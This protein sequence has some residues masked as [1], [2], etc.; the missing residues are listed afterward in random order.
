[1]GQ[2]DV[3]YLKAIVIVHG[4]SEYQICDFIK[5]KLKLNFYI[6]S[7]KKGEKS[8]QIKSVMNILK[9][10][11][12]KNFDAF[13][14]NFSAVELI[15]VEKENEKKKGTKKKKGKQRL[16][17]AFKIFIIMDTDDCTESE[18]EEFINKSMFNGHWAYDYIVPIYND[19]NLEEVVQSCGIKFEKK[20]IERKKEYIKIF[21]TDKK[22]LKKDSLQVKEFNEKLINCK[23]TNMDKFTQFCMTIVD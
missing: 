2:N 10:T 18:R 19:S 3:N 20:G 23:R 11:I 9:N 8:I 17:E 14:N 12:Y 5:S 13:I 22:Y 4:K 21:P 16:S 6:E 7:E 1:M 15:S